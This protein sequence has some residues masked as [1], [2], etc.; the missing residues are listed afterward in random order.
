MNHPFDLQAVA[1]KVYAI[2]TDHPL[3]RDDDRVLLANIWM[4]EIEGIERKDFLSHFLKGDLSNPET[5]TRVRRKL[6]EKHVKL[7]GEK[8]EGRHKMEGA[9]CQQLTFFDLW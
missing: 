4:K 9:V 5:I 6:Q 1:C 2:L 7:R 3:S 8:W